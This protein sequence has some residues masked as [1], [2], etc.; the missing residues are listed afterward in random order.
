MDLTN[1]VEVDGVRVSCISLPAALEAYKGH[2]PQKVELI[3]A[4]LNK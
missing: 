2:R 1:D 4:F 3:Q